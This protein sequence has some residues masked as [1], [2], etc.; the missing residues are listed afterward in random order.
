[1]KPPQPSF[2]LYQGSSALKGGSFSSYLHLTFCAFSHTIFLLFRAIAKNFIHKL[3]NCFLATNE[4]PALARR[5]WGWLAFSGRK[6]LTGRINNEKHK[7]AAEEF[8]PAALDFCRS[9]I[10]NQQFN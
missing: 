6:F 9:T 7:K 3:Q 10:C 1:M 4:L 2:F 5:G 8:S